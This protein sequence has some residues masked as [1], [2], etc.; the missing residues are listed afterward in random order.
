MRLGGLGGGTRG[1]GLALVYK[2][3]S[4]SSTVGALQLCDLGRPRRGTFPWADGRAGGDEGV[5]RPPRQRCKLKTGTKGRVVTKVGEPPR[6]E[7]GRQ[8]GG[9]SPG[10]QGARSGSVGPAPVGIPTS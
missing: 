8:G 3:H 2:L 10:L 6:G 7:R 5:V 9:G 1:R 4:A